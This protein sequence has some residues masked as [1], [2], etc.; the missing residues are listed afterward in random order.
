MLFVRKKT[1]AAEAGPAQPAVLAVTEGVEV[2]PAQDRGSRHAPGRGLFVRSARDVSDVSDAAE[3]VQPALDVD[4]GPELDE[5]APAEQADTGPAAASNG[6]SMPDDGPRASAR[7]GR[8]NPL[9]ALAAAW[10]KRRD[11]VATSAATRA[12]PAN[13]VKPAHGVRW[14]LRTSRERAA[15]STPETLT[16]VTELEGGRSV[17]WQVGATTLAPAQAD[18]AVFAVS[19]SAEDRRFA[20]AQPLGQRA[21]QDL[22][23][24]EIGEPV[25]MVNASRARSAVYATRASRVASFSMALAPGLQAL[26]ELLSR[27]GRARRNLVTGFVLRDASGRTLALLYH[28]DAQGELGALQVTA[29]PENMEFTLAQFVASRRLDVDSHEVVLFDNADLLSAAATLQRYPVEPVLAGLTLTQWLRTGAAAA[30]VAALA[31]GAWAGMEHLRG[32][33]LAA[34]VRALTASTKHAST[35]NGELLRSALPSFGRLMGLDTD[36]ELGRAQSLWLPGTRVTME[37]RVAETRYRLTMPVVR[38]ERVGARPSVASRLSVEEL[39]GLV[40]FAPPQGCDREGL[41]VKGA[42]NELQV[43]I[44]CKN[45]ASAFARYRLD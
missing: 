16:L 22:A 9:T 38:G 32:A 34:R 39:E 5:R 35:R 17:F 8:G 37:A 3:S 10:R 13:N 28:A 15:G 2:L 1:P 29:N 26:D 45:P 6:A 18:A 24:M 40:D 12:A 33:E 23:L 11:A 43:S 36:A 31:S 42:L 19:F 7:A 20:T 4:A 27:A 30:F 21:A 25:R 14:R 41:A 44:V